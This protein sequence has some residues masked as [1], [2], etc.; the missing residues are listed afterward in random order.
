MTA[1]AKGAPVSEHSTPAGRDWLGSVWGPAGALH[2]LCCLAGLSAG[3]WPGAIHPSSFDTTSAVL[4]TL[5]TVAIGQAAF[6]WLIYPLVLLRRRTRPGVSP[7]WRAVLVEPLAMLV[8]A[9][10]FY[11]MA[12]ALGDAGAVDVLRVALQMV[13]FW[14]IVWAAWVWLRIPSARTAVLL[15]MVLVALGGP[16]VTY[17]LL[18][19]VTEGYGGMYHAT[20][21]LRAWALGARGETL[22]TRPLWAWL[23]WP[24]V[25]AAALL[26]GIARSRRGT[27]EPP[28]FRPGRE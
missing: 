12:A 11:L 24:T 20:V 1:T 19:F 25:G 17:M 5:G 3:L 14:P 6:F 18:E 21:T 15:T 22:L 13:A 10:P 27:E 4:P 2:A 7:G 8:S 26:A 9:I 23:L 28:S 16:A